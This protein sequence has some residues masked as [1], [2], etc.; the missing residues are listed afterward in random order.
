MQYEDRKLCK[1]IEDIYNRKKSE[2][3]LD[4]AGVLRCDNRLCVPDVGDPKRTYLEET[5]NSK[6]MIHPGSTKMY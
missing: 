6:Y 2:F 3:L 1:L 5:H 4:Q